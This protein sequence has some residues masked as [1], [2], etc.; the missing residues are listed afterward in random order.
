MPDQVTPFRIRTSDADLSDLRERLAR[1]RWPEAETVDDWS[2]GVP[3]AYL[4]DLCR[5]WAD[6]FDWRAAE[7]RLNRWPQFTT[8]VDGQRIH[9]IHARAEHSGAVPLLVMHG[10]PGSVAE[11]LP[12]IEPLC[13]P[14][15]FGD[16][17]PG[18]GIG[19]FDLRQSI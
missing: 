19:A 13:D 16:D 15:S 2:Q 10:W 14:S 5:Y 4:Q 17:G 12:I 1:T 8:E 6:G 11:M 7:R 18:F 9:F 3:L